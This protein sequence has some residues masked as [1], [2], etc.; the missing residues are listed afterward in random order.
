M[1]GFTLEPCSGYGCL[2]F[3][4]PPLPCT[5][6]PSFTLHLDAS[7]LTRIG[8][9]IPLVTCQFNQI[10]PTAFLRTALH[11]Q[12]HCFYACLPSNGTIFSVC[13]PCD[14]GLD[15][16]YTRHGLHA[17]AGSE[18]HRHQRLWYGTGRRSFRL[19]VHWGSRFQIVLRELRL[20]WHGHTT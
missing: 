2:A 11:A 7:F 6:M 1:A 3:S 10:H 4:P 18:T 8:F 5:N 15:V 20:I 13:A 19:R 14:D 9:G 12:R 17:R 16:R